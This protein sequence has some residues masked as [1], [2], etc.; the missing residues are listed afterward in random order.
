MSDVIS[1]AISSS[2]SPGARPLNPAPGTLSDRVRLLKLPKQAP[3]SAARSNWLPWS[4]CFA[5]A[6]STAYLGYQSLTK[7]TN[8]SP[9]VVSN[10]TS[11]SSPDS[12]VQSPTAAP[13]ASDGG[14]AL[15][16][17]GYIIPAHQILVSPKV[18]GMIVELHIEEGK[19]VKKGD[20]LARLEDT[21]YRA[22]VQRAT[23]HLA[24]ASHRLNEMENGNRPAEIAGA[25]AEL[26]EARAM[27]E[28]YKSEFLRNNKLRPTKALSDR[29]F[30]QA[31]SAF[32][33]GERKIERLQH[34]YSLMV[35]GPRKERI[36]I[37]RAEVEQAKAELTKAQWR[38]DNCTIFAPITGTILK[39]N[40]EEGN[41]V[42]PIAFNGSYSLCDLA[43]L[44][45][46]E[47]DLNI[48]E[49]DVSRVFK[50]QKCQVRAEAFPTRVYEGV[51]SRL[52][53]IADRAKG[54]IPVRVKLTVPADEEGVYLKPEMGAIV[55]FLNG[56]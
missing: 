47:V 49:R 35:E 4:L 50:G 18:S 5:F 38:L 11:T 2:K 12:S 53:P 32:R 48:Q 1:S 22:D 19:R 25:K 43:D 51:V 37:A 44:A 29:E 16:S 3:A 52:M 27:I 6:L 34:A 7:T 20:V 55:S 36:E 41:I 46:L 8:S 17:K 15:E 30:E 45:D 10:K 56:K 42:N 26:E 39:K 14:V 21:D 24:A 9:V 23:A 40:A 31:E 33:S 28:Q 54:A 13:I